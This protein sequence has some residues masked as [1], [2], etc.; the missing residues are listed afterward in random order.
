MNCSVGNGY[1][2]AGPFLHE[3]HILISHFPFLLVPIH[4]EIT[5]PSSRNRKL[6]WL[7]VL[8]RFAGPKA[9]AMDG[10]RLTTSDL[11]CLSLYV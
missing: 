5:P 9:G 1:N 8:R 6:G 10:G 7:R 4:R 11:V 2:A 3:Q